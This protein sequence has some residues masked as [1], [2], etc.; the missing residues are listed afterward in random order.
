[1]KIKTSLFILFLILWTEK[2]SYSQINGFQFNGIKG[3]GGLE[4]SDR[5]GK[6]SGSTE[7]IIN[8]EDCYKYQNGSI[9]ITWSLNRTPATGTKYV[10]KMSKPEGSCS[11]NSLTDLGSSCQEEFVVS[12]KTLESPVN[13]KFTVTLNTLIYSDCAAQTDKTTNIYIVIEEGGQIKAETIP[14]KVDIKSP[15]PPQIF[16]IIAGEENLKVKW[17]DPDNTGESNIKYRVYYSEE[18][19]DNSTK[20]TAEKTSTLTA[21]SYQI[22]DLKNNV[23]YYVAVTAIDKSDNESNISDLVEEIPVESLDF[24]ELYKSMG[25]EEEGG[26]CSISTLN[27]VVSFNIF[28]LFLVFFLISFVFYLKQKKDF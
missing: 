2:F 18:K 12:E 20:A 17:K 22:T 26:F 15:N 1:M 21:N 6:S 24:F 8:I 10:V 16:E 11:T 19:F 3:V 9:E 14:F 25:G 27:R 13:N 4:L 7:H 5:I 28:L 23:K